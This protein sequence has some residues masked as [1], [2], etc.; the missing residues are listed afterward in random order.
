MPYSD[1]DGPPDGFEG[2]VIGNQGPEL[3][4]SPLGFEGIIITDYITGYRRPA[5]AF[6]GLVIS[7]IVT[8]RFIQVVDYRN[9]PLPNTKITVH[10]TGGDFIAFTNDIGI[11]EIVPDTSG[12]ILIDIEQYKTKEDGFSY[13]YASESVTKTIKVQ[14]STTHL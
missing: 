11:A 12:T 8:S 5:V 13:T 9:I 10:N 7:Y 1:P 14:S 2:L 3:P 6:E 4:S